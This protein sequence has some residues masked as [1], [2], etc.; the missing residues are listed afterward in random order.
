MEQTIP[1]S[2]SNGGL[3]KT[4]KEVIRE[5]HADARDLH[6]KSL[7]D[8]IRLH[9]A[10]TAWAAAVAGSANT[11]PR[12]LSRTASVRSPQKHPPFGDERALL[13]RP[14][15]PAKEESKKTSLK[16]LLAEGGEYS[17]DEEGDRGRVG[18]E[19]EDEE[20]EEE[21]GSEGGMA[22]TCGV[23]N[24]RHKGTAFIPCGH[25][26]CRLCS[27]ELRVSPGNCHLC[28][29]FVLEILDIF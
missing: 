9:H 6:W 29:E 16:A 14:R 23:C 21:G 8:G 19:D 7:K 24:V 20:D 5:D 18:R 3:E 13:Q 22:R 27:R 28:N 15:P 11:R 25:T 4:L 17:D 2:G 1:K 26:F 10:S 12:N